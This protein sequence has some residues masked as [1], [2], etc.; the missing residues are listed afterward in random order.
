MANKFLIEGIDRLGK[1]S[2]VA[3][4]QQVR[5][6]HVVIHHS[7][8]LKLECYNFS[9]LEYQQ[10]TFRSMFSMLRDAR[11]TPIICDRAHLGE[12]VYGPMYRQTSGDYVFDLEQAFEMHMTY[13][14][15]LVLLTEDFDIAEHFVDDGESFDITKRRSEQQLFLNA[16]ERSLMPDKRVVSVT[17]PGTGGF[18]R[19]EQILAE[20]LE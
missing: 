14:T 7:K 13:N 6:Y 17:D 18:K 1:S 3:G 5:G 11:Y 12:A 10:H 2:L 8:P 15:R 20:V 19:R 16:F 4:I 9:S